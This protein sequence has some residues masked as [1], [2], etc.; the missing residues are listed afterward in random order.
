MLNAYKRKASSLAASVQQTLEC[1]LCVLT[2]P[3]TKDVKMQYHKYIAIPFPR[4][5]HFY[6]HYDPVLIIGTLMATTKL[7]VIQRYLLVQLQSCPLA[8]TRNHAVLLIMQ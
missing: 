2:I 8:I 6:C 7:A 5:P 3:K 1:S 4:H